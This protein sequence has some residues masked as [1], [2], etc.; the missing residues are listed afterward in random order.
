VQTRVTVKFLSGEEVAGKL[1]RTFHPESDCIELAG[2]EGSG[3]QRH[4]LDTI[5]YLKLFGKPVLP[6]SDEQ[7]HFFEKITTVTG[8]RFHLRLLRNQGFASG[9]YGYP[10]DPDS[11]FSAIFITSSGLSQHHHDHPLGQVLLQQGAV[12]AAALD[13]ALSNQRALRQKRVGEILTEQHSLSKNTVERTLLSAQHQG[14]SSACSRVGEILIEAGLVTRQQVDEALAIQATEKRKRIGTILMELGMITEEQLLSALAQKFGLQ[15]VDLDRVTPTPEALKCLS[16]EILV[17]MQV[18]P[19]EIRKKRLVVATANPTDPVIAQNLRFAANLPIELVVASGGQ[20]AAQIA[21]LATARPS[22]I[23]ELIGGLDNPEVQV[24]EEQELDH[25]NESDS[26]VINL[27]NKVLLDAHRR[28]VSDIHFEPGMGALPLKIRYRKDGVC[29]QVHQISATF[30]AAILSRIKIIAKLDIAERRRPQSGKILLKH[31]RERIE[32]RVEVT[33]TIGGQED[34]VLRVLSSAQIFPLEQIGF[35]T[36]NLERMREALKKP[37][38]LILCVGPTGSG[39]TTTLH[40]CISEINTP[41]RKIWTAE[42]PVEITQE[43]LRQVQVHA[44]IG[45]TFEEALRS[46]L[47]AD[48]DVIMIGE[49][50][51]PVTAKTAIGA[52]LTGH[53]VFSTLHTN[54]AAE[55][56]VRLIEMGMDPFNFADAMLTIVA[57]RLARRLCTHCNEPYHPARAEYD[58]LVDA[59]G[60]EQFRQDEMPP[61][62]AELTLMRAK[63]C[64]KCEGTGYSGRIAVHEQ[65]VNSPPIRQAIKENAGVEKILSIAMTQGMSTLR[66]DGIQKIFLGLT[67]FKQISRVIT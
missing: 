25:V 61:F 33:P 43:G 48:P 53:L 24:V 54:S 58:E 16:Q 45:F 2:T 62:S 14:K 10:N 38:G 12:E 57:Q 23:E 8:D 52:S 28:G 39:K 37:Y 66:M 55:T 13:T 42:D 64:E 32:Y 44:K 50:R 41:D 1:K 56:V 5:A 60:R 4:Q 11:D 30:K 6:E 46:F 34:A 59:Y 67:D 35:S 18:L 7:D 15:V 40:S 21:R 20:I 31:G 3:P 27:V 49:M 9:F 65:L 29:T 17:K 47:R 22:G 51:D 26:K 36:R 63:G 19:L